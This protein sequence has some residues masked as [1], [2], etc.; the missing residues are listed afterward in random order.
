MP[1]LP[2]FDDAK[3]KAKETVSHGRNLIPWLPDPPTCDDC[4]SLLYA[5]VTFDPHQVQ[6]VT[7]WY[8]QSCDVHRYRDPEYGDDII[9]GPR[10]GSP[11]LRELF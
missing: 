2:T 9:S 4:D 3:Q 10:E 6:Y 1:D 11:L 5:D 8:C 7:S